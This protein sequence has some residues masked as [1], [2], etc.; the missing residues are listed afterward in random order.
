[1]NEDD[2]FDKRWWVGFLLTSL[3]FVAPLQAQ[4]HAYAFVDFEILAQLHVGGL[5]GAPS[6]S[7]EV[8]KTVNE[9][10]YDTLGEVAEQ[11]GFDY[12]LNR[13]FKIIGVPTIAYADN[14]LV[15]DITADV[16]YRLRTLKPTEW[17]SVE[18]ARMPV[19]PQPTHRTVVQIGF[20]DFA[21]LQ[22][23]HHKTAEE[24][25]RF[26]LVRARKLASVDSG[27]AL[28]KQVETELKE[29]ANAVQLR[30]TTEIS[31]IIE[32]VAIAK[33]FHCIINRTF[34]INGV[35]TLAYGSTAKVKD[36]TEEVLS[37]LNQ[38]APLDWTPP[39]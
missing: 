3:L 15:P 21:R 12:V 31:Q 28:A 10:I 13:S 38:T 33:G 5:D 6:K 17:R 30:L 1:M 36:I 8:E 2:V 4:T 18:A 20:V 24:R 19:S 35:P 27:S 9:F 26:Q 22:R 11:L 37:L 29:E 32:S 23:G 25:E 39:P 7:P 16:A 34:G 14:K